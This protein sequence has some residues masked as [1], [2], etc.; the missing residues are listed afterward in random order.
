MIY[1][2]L[3]SRTVQKVNFCKRRTHCVLNSVEF[4][5]IVVSNSINS[6]G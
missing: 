2:F 3:N 4:R 1:S 6:A 5:Q